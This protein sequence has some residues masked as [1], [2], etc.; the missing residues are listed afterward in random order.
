MLK[1]KYNLDERGQVIV[2]AALLIVFLVGMTA[3]AVD[4]GSM[5]QERRHVQ[6]TA[7]SA[8]LAGAQDLPEAP[9][10][11]VQTAIA[12]A[13]L[14]GVNVTESD[15]ILSNTYLPSDS[16]FEF[17]TIRVVPTG[18]EAQLFFAPVLNVDSTTVTAAATAVAGNPKSMNGLMPWAIPMDEYPEG[19]DYGES[20]PLKVG[21]NQKDAPGWFQIMGFDGTGKNVY[22]D[23]IENGCETEIWIDGFYP[24]ETGV[25][26]GPTEQG[27]IERL[28]EEH[29]YCTFEEVVGVKLNEETG[30][31]E[32][33]VKKSC[34]RIVY[35]PAIEKKPVPGDKD[36][37]VI[38][39]YVFFL[40]YY[41]DAIEPNTFKITGKFVQNSI[42]V[43]SGEITGYSGGIKVIRLIE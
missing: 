29:K 38:K 27:I 20:Y 10:E 24:V 17:D 28:G 16:L 35:I 2:I 19:L 11:A 33:Y 9:G 30:E 39:F 13:T 25:G 23:T 12:Y 18:V 7:D 4:V 22:R 41:E 43:S 15:V 8:A 40:E 34:P 5:Y 26:A 6:N 14:N 37:K 31:N 3:L 1:R 36:V 21:P 32:Y 42:A